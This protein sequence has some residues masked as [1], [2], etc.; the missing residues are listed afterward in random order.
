MSIS[1]DKNCATNCFVIFDLCGMFGTLFLPARSGI[2]EGKGRESDD[3]L[4][5]LF[6]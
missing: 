2:R 3:V 6:Y 5:E 1:E 4:T